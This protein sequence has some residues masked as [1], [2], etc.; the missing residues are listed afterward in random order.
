[1]RCLLVDDEPGIREGLA[2]LL[3]RKGH[4]V[5][6]AGDGA[7]AGA[8]LAHDT[9]D[10]VVTDWRLPD[11]TARTF[12]A[13]CRVPVVAISGHPEEVDADVAEVLTKPVAP[14]HLFEVL[15]GLTAGA[16][17]PPAT[18]R[19]SAA[20]EAASDLAALPADVRRLAAAFRALVGGELCDDGP[21]VVLR[22]ELA[23]R[24]QLTALQ[25][26]GG[27]LQVLVR[28]AQEHVQLRLCR[29][30]RPHLDLPVVAAGQPWP[31]RGE[32][33]VDFA[34]SGT[35]AADCAEFAG[36]LERAARRRA[37]GATVH[38]LNLPAAFREWARSHGREHELPMQAVVGPRLPAL[39][40][41][42][43][44]NP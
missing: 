35:T 6:T 43:W 21:F 39:F 15:T 20:S 24:S 14:A 33:A 8:A 7:A 34:A 37:A 23:D 31:V 22:G 29:D 38:F 13:Q 32:F 9:F 12:L 30:G 27:D 25:A 44:S 3:R 36:H 10:V 28:G 19:A 40:A 17:A 42:L 41:D 16:A 26:L 5:V 18:A 2:A 4:Q 11:G 1:M